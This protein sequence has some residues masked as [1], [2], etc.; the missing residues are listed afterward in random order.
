MALDEFVYTDESGT[1][2]GA[3]WCMSAGYAGDPIQWQLFNA[4]WRKAMAASG[5]YEPF[6]AREFFRRKKWT[7]KKFNQFVGWDDARA[8][9][10]IARLG[11][12]INAYRIHAVGAGVDVEAFHSLPPEE[13]VLFTGHQPREGKVAAPY[14]MVSW[15]STSA[16]IASVPRGTTVWFKIADHQE[17]APQAIAT[18][19]DIKARDTS[20]LAQYLGSMEPL[21]PKQWPGLQAADLLAYLWARKY[22]LGGEHRLSDEERSTYVAI[23][24]RPTMLLYK[25]A[26]QLRETVDW[27]RASQA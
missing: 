25:D 2:A 12:V 10:L 19:L 20:G 9:R 14:Y 17:Y 1:H 15:L 4:G 27:W 7:N 18:F 11:G 24:R 22:Q 5:A 3:R 21:S 13:Q 8:A 16:A 23:T 26:G 6:H